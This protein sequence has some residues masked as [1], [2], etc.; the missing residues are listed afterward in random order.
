[1]DLVKGIPSPEDDEEMAVDDDDDKGDVE[2][3]R[4]IPPPD[5]AVDE[6]EDVQEN[7]STSAPDDIDQQEGRSTLQAQDQS[8]SN[9]EDEH[10]APHI[11]PWLRKTVKLCNLPSPEVVTPP[12]D[13]PSSEV[14]APPSNQ[15]ALR[16]NHLSPHADTSSIDSSQVYS[17]SFDL[18]SPTLD[19]QELG[20]LDEHA[21]IFEPFPFPNLSEASV[22]FG[23]RSASEHEIDTFGSC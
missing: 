1:M 15:L 14:V 7:R 22:E 2:D 10:R 21:P 20:S 5:D 9:E 17:G 4:S 13:L 18:G 23:D 8:L 3:N 11:P 6:R 19:S 16:S 12:S